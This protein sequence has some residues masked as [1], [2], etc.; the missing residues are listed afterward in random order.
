MIADI[1]DFIGVFDDAISVDHCNAF[2][3]I[4]KD[5]DL[6]G[7]AGSR[8]QLDNAPRGK[9]DGDQIFNLD[10]PG[11]IFGS[12]S[13][14]FIDIF[15][16][17][18]YATYIDKYHTLQDMDPH[19]VFNFK[20]Q[21]IDIGQGYHI[22]HHENGSKIN[23]SRFLTFILYLN[24]VA[25]GGETE[26]LFYPRRVQPKAGRLLLFPGAFTHSHRGNPPLSNT[27]YIING[28]IEF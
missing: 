7:L 4:Y 12:I 17:Q 26:F 16:Q 20:M 28:W 21:K 15:N 25:E 10:I 23:S 11:H 24:D 19:G 27:K 5:L 1:K 18:I 6:K 3:D 13:H 8:Q 22:W 2:I 9:K 14:S